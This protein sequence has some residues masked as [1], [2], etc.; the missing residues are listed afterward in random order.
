MLEIKQRMKDSYTNL[1]GLY[2]LAKQYKNS[3]A[4]AGYALE[5]NQIN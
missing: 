3:I 2:Y 5:L 1:S 4:A